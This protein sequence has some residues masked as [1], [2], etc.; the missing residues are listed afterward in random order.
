MPNVINGNT[1]DR[2]ECTYTYGDRNSHTCIIFIK[3]SQRYSKI[4]LNGGPFKNCSIP[5][6]DTPQN[7]GIQ[8]YYI[9]SRDPIPGIDYTNWEQYNNAPFDLT[10]KFV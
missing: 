7:N 4:I 5:Y 10:I 2:V 8:R 1:I 9:S 3:T 6:D